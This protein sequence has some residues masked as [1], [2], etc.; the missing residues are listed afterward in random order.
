MNPYSHLLLAHLIGDALGV[1]VEFCDRDELHFEP[2]RGMRSGG[3]WGRHAGTWSDDGAL[4]LCSW[5]T[6][7]TEG[8]QP[9]VA[10]ARFDRWFSKGYWAVNNHVF[11]IGIA[12]KKAI[13]AYQRQLSPPWGGTSEFDNGNGSLM[14]ILPVALALKDLPTGQLIQR[15]G[16][17]SALTHAH[18]R[19]RA[20]CQIYALVI[21][22]LLHGHA[23][24][25]ALARAVKDIKPWLAA[26]DLNPLDRILDGS[27][28]QADEDAISSD[29]YVV[30][31]LEAS[32]W[33]LAKGGSFADITLRAVNLGGDTDTTAAITAPLAAIVHGPEC[34]PA[35]WRDLILRQPGLSELMERQF[36]GF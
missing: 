22:E 13:Q 23:V 33:C 9:E 31:S 27:V 34:L 28:L 20:C 26:D 25:V 2:V 16:T 32:L 12:T 4:M 15:V 6:L 30:H 3:R 17:W 19:S 21:R 14:R 10:M 8:D 7:V 18:S 1:P 5:E 24:A 35:E 11:D 36:V 29:G